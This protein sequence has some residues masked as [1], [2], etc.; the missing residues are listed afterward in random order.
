MIDQEKKDSYI[1]A[2]ITCIVMIVIYL[3]LIFCGISYREPE[4]K[5]KDVTPELL[6]EEEEE[7]F[8]EPEILKDLGE[9]NA[10]NNDAP[11]KVFQGEPK[12]APVENTKIVVP[13]KNPNPAPPVD[14]L[15][16]TKHES[17]VKTTEPSVSDEERQQ[18]TSAMAKSFSG[19]NG[20]PQGSSGS[21]GVGSTGIGVKGNAAGRTFLSCPSPSVTLRHQTTVTVSVVID[22]D[23]KVISASASGGA[24]AEIRRACENA[25]RQARWSAKKGAA[26]TRGSITFK[27]YPK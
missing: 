27:I 19:R 24:S 12:P 23:G 11:A 3:L 22:A 18:V 25:A 17:P 13:G 5:P 20:T 2:G 1:S 26:E 8:I 21:D 14:K 6:A 9:E 10:V 7:T 15:I 4:A 16:S